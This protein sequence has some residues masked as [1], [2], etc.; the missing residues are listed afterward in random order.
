VEA[1]SIEVR[2]RI[3]VTV[4]P[5]TSVAPEAIQN[6]IQLIQLQG[7]HKDF[8]AVTP[9]RLSGATAFSWGRI[10]Q[11]QSGGGDVYIS[12]N[13]GP[14]VSAAQPGRPFVSS[15]DGTVATHD[16]VLHVQIPFGPSLRQESM[17]ILQD[18][19]FL[20]QPLDWGNTINLLLTLG[21]A[22]ALGDPTGAT[23]TFTGFGSAAGTPQVTAFQNFALL[24]QFQNQMGRSGVVVRNEQQLQNQVALANRALLAQLAHQITPTVVLKSGTFQ[25]GAAPSANIDTLS[26]LSD[27]MLE[28]TQLTVDNKQLRNNLNNLMMKDYHQRMF[29]TQVPEGYFP[30]TFAE[31][32]TSL[33]AYRGDRLPGGSQLN[34]ESNIILAIANA[35]LRMVQEYCLGGPFPA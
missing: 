18:M 6:L 16:F 27:L 15:F 17:A 3:N 19:N 12:R 33:T 34:L 32:G 8:G 9:T 13:G 35:R 11:L 24:G 2:G 22:S 21:D 29:N 14:L 28:Q 1:L 26:A 4:A 31:S 5:F 25:T 10:F 30:L 7:N 23:V 20:L